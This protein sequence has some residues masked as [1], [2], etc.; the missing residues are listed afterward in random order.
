MT[1]F[2]IRTIR[3]KSTV[4]Q[5]WLSVNCTNLNYYH[6]NSL[7]LFFFKKKKKKK[8]KIYRQVFLCILLSTSI[9]LLCLMPFSCHIFHANL[10]KKKISDDLFE[11]FLFTL[12]LAGIRATYI[13]PF[14]IHLYDY[15]RHI[16]I[17]KY[18]FRFIA[19]L[20]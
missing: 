15:N 7:S 10:L 13:L 2:N 8:K 11:I 6:Y 16:I 4:Y 19:W 20:L 9:F 18:F 5:I 17:I 3:I 12:V 14:P 1:N